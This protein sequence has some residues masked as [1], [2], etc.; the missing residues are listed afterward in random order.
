MKNYL[1]PFIAVI[2]SLS[3][4]G[5]EPSAINWLGLE[6]DEWTMFAG[7]CTN[8]SACN[9]DP[10]ATF[11][12]GSCCLENCVTINIGASDFPNE[13]SY[14]LM[15]DLGNEYLNV[16]SGPNPVDYNLCLPNGCYV[17]HMY[18]AFGDGWN[19]GTYTI[20]LENTGENK[21]AGLFPNDPAFQAF[22]KDVYFVLGPGVLGCDDIAACN[23]DPSVTCNNGTCDYTS[24]YGCTD[25][26]ACNFSPTAVFDDGSCCLENCL[27][28]ELID[29]VGDGWDLGTYTIYDS[30]MNL[31]VEG[32]L[33]SPLDYDLQSLCLP[34]GCYYFSVQ[35][36]GYPEEIEWIL[37]GIDAG[38]VAGDGLTVTNTY[39][40]VGGGACFGCTEPE[41]CTYNP[42]A[43]IDDGSCIEGP[44]V[45][46]DNPWTARNIT[47]SAYPY[48]SYQT[49]TVEGATRTQ[50]AYS[51][52]T[53]GEDIWFRFTAPTNGVSIEVY[54]ASFDIVLELLD[55]EWHTITSE[56]AVAGVGS[57]NFNSDQIIPG[58][59]YYLG[60]RNYNSAI[61]TGSFR[62]KAQYLRETGCNTASSELNLCGTFKA[63]YVYAKDYIFNFT[64]TQTSELLSHY[65]TNSNI[66]M[67]GD[68]TGIS[69]DKEY[70]ISVDAVYQL[71]DG[72][73][74]P[75]LYTVIDQ[76][77]CTKTT[78]TPGLVSVSTA[79][80]CENYGGINRYK[81][82]PFNPRI[83]AAIGYQIKLV[84]QDGVQEPI[85][86]NS[87]NTT[88]YFRF[89]QIPEAQVG[90]F[91]DVSIRPLFDIEYEA[92]W[93][94]SV[95]LQVAGTSSF[96]TI[97][98][99]L[100]D[101]EQEEAERAEPLFVASTYPN[102]SNGND[103]NVV[104]N[105]DEEILVK[106]TIYDMTGKLVLQ[107]QVV[108][109]G[110]LNQPIPMNQPLATGIYTVIFEG[111]GQYDSQRMIIQQP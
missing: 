37:S 102:P 111:N 82:I 14:V 51:E 8:P 110:E 45:A 25:G 18:D 31:I 52:V 72:T 86:Y 43:F 66:I 47:L 71:T 30:E 15:D 44:C 9:F 11:D 17:F 83:C 13:M 106:Y 85:I 27:S 60:V 62:I 68:V 2:L 79:Y 20:T 41:A 76:D 73:G 64:D 40:S 19:N 109:D 42:F 74:S 81:Y 46:Y 61:G 35:G 49:F 93:G 28:L 29:Y 6:N 21:G 50:V 95:C 101:M 55:S 78:N 34:D 105:T 99:N 3:A 38:T 12:D 36:S 23:Y 54:N 69:Y 89:S 56:N 53:T 84:N 92:A 87:L 63:G 1:T 67:L 26:A 33:A 58:E 77:F 80:S 39:F 24:C 97:S 59:T 22:Q 100:N 57:E 16:S 103:V 98:N 104:I 70:D 75:S 32:T 107:K 7:G 91:Y 108:V 90:A 88:R 5:R 4:M 65:A 48:N 96:W 94:P 10:A